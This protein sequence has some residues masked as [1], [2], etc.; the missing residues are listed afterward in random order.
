ML[1][2]LVNSDV[3]VL[4][5]IQVDLQY[6]RGATTVLTTSS[7]SALV[8]YGR[9]VYDTSNR[10]PHIVVAIVSRLDSKRL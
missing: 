4:L 1:L 6:F 2:H 7:S 10:T 3:K 5:S 9:A 8:E